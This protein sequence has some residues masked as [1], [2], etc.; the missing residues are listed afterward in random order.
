[1]GFYSE[2]SRYYD[3]IFVA[4]ASELA[5]VN[6]LLHGRKTVLDVGCGT[7]NKTEL[8]STADNTIHAFD[9]DPEMI[10]RAKAK[11]PGHSIE[12]LVSDMLEVDKKY[13]GLSFD[14]ALCLGNT[15]VHLDSEKQIAEMLKKL[16][17]LLSADGI[18]VIQILNYDWIIR[19]N[20]TELPLIETESVV[21][22]RHY[23]WEDGALFF[24]ADL[25]VKATGETVQNR[26][27]LFPLLKKDLTSLLSQS[28]FTELEFYGGYDGRPLKDDSFVLIVVA[29]KRNDALR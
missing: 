29:R 25:V 7:G 18:L 8:F 16:D 14:A 13:A 24:K 3:E 6:R 20:I 10:A 2:I 28:A 26:V 11:H 19:Q 9:S 22:S 27:R 17:D 4:G 12:Y 1:M 5:F 21:F 15:F 23:E